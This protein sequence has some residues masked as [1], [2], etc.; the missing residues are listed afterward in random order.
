VA[1]FT[2]LEVSAH[3]R[4]PMSSVQ[5]TRREVVKELAAGGSAPADDY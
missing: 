5:A 4:L 2:D 1:P 3:R